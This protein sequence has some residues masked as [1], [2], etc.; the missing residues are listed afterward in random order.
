M[1]IKFTSSPERPVEQ[2]GAKAKATKKAT[3]P[4]DE[5]MEFELSNESNG[6]G[7]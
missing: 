4:S 6:K 7:E 2:K 5:N 1:A 3:K